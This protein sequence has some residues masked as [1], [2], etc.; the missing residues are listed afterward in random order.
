M[1]QMKV[2]LLLRQMCDAVKVK[3][4]D[5]AI[6]CTWYRS[7]HLCDPF[8]DIELLHVSVKLDFNRRNLIT[9]YLSSNRNSFLWSQVWVEI[10]SKKCQNWTENER[11]LWF[12]L[13]NKWCIALLQNSHPF[14]ATKPEIKYIGRAKKW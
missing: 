9:P 1:R 6:F 10:E 5:K 7:S 3:V 8:N 14:V 12:A 4:G 2:Y 13:K 11:L